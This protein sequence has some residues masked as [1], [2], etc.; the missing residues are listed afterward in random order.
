[1]DY[2][3]KQQSISPVEAQLRDIL[4]RRIMILDGAMGTMIQRYKL[5]E[6]DYRGTRF[7]DF[8]PPLP[9]RALIWFCSDV[10]WLWMLLTF[11]CAACSDVA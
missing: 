3:M 10:I 5:T 1:M 4:K 6:A 7:A 8:A 11:C 2:R 9:S